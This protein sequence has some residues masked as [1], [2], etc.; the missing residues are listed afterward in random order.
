M[1]RIVILLFLTIVNI[2]LRIYAIEYVTDGLVVNQSDNTYSFTTTEMKQ[3]EKALVES[4]EM[5]L[6]L[7]IVKKLF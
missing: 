7:T 3:A 1:K 6:S 5:V 4:F 2:H